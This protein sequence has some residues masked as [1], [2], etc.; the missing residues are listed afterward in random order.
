MISYILALYIFTL[1]LNL[2]TAQNSTG[3]GYFGY[4]LEQTGDPYST[5]YATNET[6]TA[7][8]ASL[9]DPPPDVFLNASV[10][11]GTIDLTV[12][13]ITA[14]INL[15][16]QVLSLLQ[17][18]AGISASID[19]VE[20]LIE[21]VNAKVLLEARLGNLV[22]MIGDVLDSLDLNPVLATLGQDVSNI[23][24]T[25]VGD[26]TGSSSSSTTEKRSYNLANNILYSINDYSGHT[27]T[28]RILAQNG[29]IIQQSLDN[30]GNIYVAFQS[31]SNY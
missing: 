22:T 24:N 19:R 11:V 20:L 4:S 3:D 25:T 28:N 16:A 30:N 29:S 6:D 9:S 14:N 5:I 7:G 21:E 1:F 17:F 26:L 15:E 10:H 31:A 12:T 13:N 23:V 2:S 27:H 8:N 18:N